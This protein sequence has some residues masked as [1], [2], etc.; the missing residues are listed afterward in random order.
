[1]GEDTLTATLDNIR[2]MLE[3]ADKRAVIVESAEGLQAFDWSPQ[4]AARAKDRR[5]VPIFLV[6]NV[7]GAPPLYPS[8]GVVSRSG[9]D[10]V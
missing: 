10:M 7:T 8:R 6:S 5:T 3:C 1:M 2:G 4:E 9:S